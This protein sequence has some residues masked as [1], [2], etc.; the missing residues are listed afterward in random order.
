MSVLKR[1]PNGS[2]IRQCITEVYTIDHG[3]SLKRRL[4][5]SLS[6]TKSGLSAR[7]DLDKIEFS[8]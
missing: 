7:W 8:D 1:I 2:R 3:Y 5:S 4:G 6:G